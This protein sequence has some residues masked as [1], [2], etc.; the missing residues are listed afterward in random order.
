MSKVAEFETRATIEQQAREWLIRLDGDQRLSAA[1]REELRAW[2]DR[3]S[4]HREALTRVSSFWKQANALTELAV[5][6]ARRGSEHARVSLRRW[7]TLAPILAGIVAAA[8]VLSWW[9]ERSD[10]AA[11]GTYG[12]AIGQQQTLTLPDKSSLQLNTDSQVQVLYS[13]GVRSVRLLRGEALFTVAPNPRRPF[14]VH[15][16]DGV[17]RAVGT[18]FSV[19]LDGGTVDVTVT[20]GA[21]EVSELSAPFPPATPNST[22]HPPA[23]RLGQ[24]KAGETTRFSA[25]A[26]RI[27]VRVLAAPEMERRLAWHEGYLVFSGEPLSEVVAQVNRY[28]PVTLHIADPKLA[29]VGVGGR[30]RIGDLDAILDVLH[31]EFGVRSH[32]IDEREIELESERPR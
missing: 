17:V 1:E 22:S 6:L 2:M 9:L 4:L 7:Q 16:V 12:T 27:N 29:S 32:R 23:R 10:G 26:Q 25:E 24:L 5:P 8:L 13:A 15:A 21:V 30:F 18:A 3:S 20:N 19:H 28:S 14:E 11:N 31:T